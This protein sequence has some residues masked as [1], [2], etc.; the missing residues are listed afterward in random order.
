MT[1]RRRSRRDTLSAGSR[2]LAAAV[3]RF[4]SLESRALLSVAASGALTLGELAQAPG[5]RLLQRAHPDP[6]WDA[7][8]TPRLGPVPDQPYGQWVIDGAELRPVVAIWLSLTDG[9]GVAGLERRPFA[10]GP[11]DLDG[12]V[13]GPQYVTPGGRGPRRRGQDINFPC[14]PR[15]SRAMTT[16]YLEDEGAAQIHLRDLG[17]SAA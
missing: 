17:S 7:V 6:G 10:D 2:S 4:E 14:A 5:A 15:Y 12:P 13:H 9:E 11:H 16:G 1:S 8:P 3:G